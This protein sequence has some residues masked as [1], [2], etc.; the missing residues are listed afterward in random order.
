MLSKGEEIKTRCKTYFQDLLTNSAAVIQSAPLDVSY[1]N[2]A[3]TE[4]ELKKN[5]KIYWT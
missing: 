2:Q 4:E 5:L 1:V 3:A